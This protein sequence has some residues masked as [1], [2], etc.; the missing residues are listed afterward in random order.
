MFVYNIPSTIGINLI[1]H[2]KYKVMEMIIQ[3]SL[4][5][6]LNTILI[7]IASQ[8]PCMLNTFKERI[9]EDIVRHFPSGNKHQHSCG[10]LFPGNFCKKE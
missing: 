1:P 8:D 10:E 5:M 7:K 2:I 4:N 6:T 3:Y 9:I